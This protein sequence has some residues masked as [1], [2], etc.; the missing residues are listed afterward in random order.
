MLGL[1]LAPNKAN[2]DQCK[3]TCNT[4]NGCVG[5]DYNSAA[6][7]QL[8]CWIQKDSSGSRTPQGFGEQVTHYEQKRQCTGTSFSSK[9]VYCFQ[10][11]FNVQVLEDVQV[12]HDVP[13]R[14]LHFIY[15]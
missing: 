12:Q 3:T 8:A 9:M 1:T 7:T 10:C 5:F 13:P 14:M 11:T 15:F 2:V 6:S 4:D